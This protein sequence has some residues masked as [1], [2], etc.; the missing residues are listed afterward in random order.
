M[1]TP[2]KDKKVTPGSFF[3][4]MLTSGTSQIQTGA[5]EYGDETVA[6][7]LFPK[8]INNFLLDREASRNTIDATR[9]GEL[10]LGATAPK[11]TPDLADKLIQRAG[12]TSLER[13][14]SKQGRRSA[15]LT[16]GIK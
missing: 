9:A 4:S 13:Q 14:Q 15:F 2:Q 11:A 16:G 3:L 7:A 1:G 5:G 12:A 8:E 6:D 10:A